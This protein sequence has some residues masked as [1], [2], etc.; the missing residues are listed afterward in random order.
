LTN[1]AARVSLILVSSTHPRFTLAVAPEEGVDT[2]ELSRAVTEAARGLRYGSVEVVVHDGRVAQ[3]I[4]TDR[5][6][7]VK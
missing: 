5:R 4:R 7:V 6:R 1:G 3:I 2:A